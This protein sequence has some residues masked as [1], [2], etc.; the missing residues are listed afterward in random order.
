MTV[1]LSIPGCS[2][3]TATRAKHCHR[4]I[5]RGR[6]VSLTA[7][8]ACSRYSLSTTDLSRAHRAQL[9]PPSPAVVTAASPD[10]TSAGQLSFMSWRYTSPTC[11][12]SRCQP[13]VSRPE[14]PPLAPLL[15]GL[16]GW[17]AESS[18]QGQRSQAQPLAPSAD[19][20]RALGAPI[21]EQIGPLC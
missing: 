16:E 1:S 11:Q 14:A 19:Q 2:C 12:H 4:C 15:P 8:A 10:T 20:R 6:V 3:R 18:G 5:W 9:L 21:S 17:G 7:A 13:A